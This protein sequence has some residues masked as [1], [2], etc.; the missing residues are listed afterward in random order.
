M[1]VRPYWWSQ[2]Q[3]RASKAS[4]LI[5]WRLV[6]SVA[7]CFSTAFWRRDAGVVVARLEE[8]VQALH[9]LEAHDRVGEGEL[10]RMAHVSLPVTFGGGCATTKL[11][12]DSSGSAA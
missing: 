3:T 6:P 11:S 9:A 5:F 1:I 4:R 2:S 10:E 7:R 8:R 12:R